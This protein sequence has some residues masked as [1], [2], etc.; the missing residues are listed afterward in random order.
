MRFLVV[1]TARNEKKGGNGSALSC[2]VVRKVFF[3]VSPTCGRR[4]SHWYA[5]AQAIKK[6]NFFLKT[7]GKR[8]RVCQ[9]LS[10]IKCTTAYFLVHQ[11]NNTQSLWFLLPHGYL[12]R[13][14]HTP[15]A[16]FS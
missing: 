5:V 12:Y 9:V 8:T 14:G 1:R 4:Y 15:H 13:N 2:L 11:G 10:S 7:L 3:S 6:Q 16:S